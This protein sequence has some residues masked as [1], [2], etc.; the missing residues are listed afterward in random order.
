[1]KKYFKNRVLSNA[2]T[3]SRKQGLDP[4]WNGVVSLRAFGCS[5]RSPRASLL[6][7]GID[8]GSSSSLRVSAS[9]P[10]P[11]NCSHAD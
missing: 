2:F 8:S 9:C 7:S 4:F 10:G 11:Y 5:A 6:P 1:M 3:L